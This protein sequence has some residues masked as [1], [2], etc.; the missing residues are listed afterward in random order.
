MTVVSENVYKNKLDEIVC[1]CNNTYH[2]TIKMKPADVK[3]DNYVDFGVDK[4]DKDPE[5]KVGDYVKISKHR[6]ISAKEYTPNQPKE[7]F[8][9]K[10]VKNT[11]LWTYVIE[12]IV[13][14]FN[15]LLIPLKQQFFVC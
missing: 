7:V 13:D 3:V 4:N 14:K 5:F 2:R 1:Q 8:V 10:N 9:T 12:D 11:V 15:I 6:N